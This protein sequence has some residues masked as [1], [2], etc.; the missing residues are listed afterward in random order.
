MWHKIYVSLGDPLQVS[1]TPSDSLLACQALNGPPKWAFC[2]I[3][4]Y[5]I[6]S[7]NKYLGIF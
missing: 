5:M 3:L 1:S 2:E 4:G 7:N 6:L